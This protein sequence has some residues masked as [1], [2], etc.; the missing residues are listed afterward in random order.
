MTYQQEYKSFLTPKLISEKREYQPLQMIE[1]ITNISSSLF[2]GKS[3]QLISMIKLQSN[4]SHK[5]EGNKKKR[6]PIGADSKMQVELTAIIGYSR[7]KVT[8]PKYNADLLRIFVWIT[9]K[10]SKI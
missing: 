2:T 10:D 4:F 5:K 3:F 9:S 6:T 8:I 7:S 1:K